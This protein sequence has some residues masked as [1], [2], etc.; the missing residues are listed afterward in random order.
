MQSQLC[1]GRDIKQNQELL[2][3][4]T[5]GIH[6][7]MLALRLDTTGYSAGSTGKGYSAGYS[8]RSTGKLLWRD[9][10]RDPL[11]SCSG[12]MLGGIHWPAALAGYSAGH[13]RAALY[14]AGSTGEQL[15]RDTGRDPLAS[16]SGVIRGRLHWRAALGTRRDPLAI[17]SGGILGGCVV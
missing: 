8:A 15:W 3:R 2:W 5:G 10:R 14:S 16:R 12:G 9:A 13:W 11:A 17:C 1:A 7:R 4:D 6:W